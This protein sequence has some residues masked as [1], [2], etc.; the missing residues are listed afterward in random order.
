M[1]SGNLNLNTLPLVE[2]SEEGNQRTFDI[3]DARTLPVSGNRQL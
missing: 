1:M 3:E 2:V